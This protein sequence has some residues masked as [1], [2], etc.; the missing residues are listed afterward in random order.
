MRRTLIWIGTTLDPIHA[1]DLSF[2]RACTREESPAIVLRDAEAFMIA[3]AREQ[4]KRLV[5]YFFK[6]PIY[7]MQVRKAVAKESMMDLIDMGE[8]AT[9]ANSVGHLRPGGSSESSTAA[10]LTPIGES[11]ASASSSGGSPSSSSSTSR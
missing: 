6:R 9:D 7:G 3:P 10:P 1:S 8:F 5:Y 11:Q 2:V 4:V